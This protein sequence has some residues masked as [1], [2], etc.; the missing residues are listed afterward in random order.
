M[1]NEEGA[2]DG[3]EI[4]TAKD[5]ANVSFTSFGNLRSNFSFFST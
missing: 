5:L 4:I 3:D 1:E 2:E